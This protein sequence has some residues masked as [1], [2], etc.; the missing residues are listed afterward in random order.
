MIKKFLI[1]TIFLLL[2]SSQSNAAGSNSDAKPKTHFD[3]AVTYI[4][5]AKKLEKKGD[6][7]KAQKRYKRAIKFLLK[8]NKDNPNK[9][10]TLNFWVLQQEKLA[11]AQNCGQKIDP[12]TFVQPEKV[13]K[14]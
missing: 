3:K 10:D 1:S 11:K 8:S 2:L 5:A 9:P 12:G 6:L 13:A 14:V 7:D 4:K